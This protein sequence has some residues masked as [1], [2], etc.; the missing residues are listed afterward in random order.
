MA[1]RLSEAIQDL[2]FKIRPEGY[3]QQASNPLKMEHRNT[4]ISLCGLG[5]FCIC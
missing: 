2:I 1:Q 4:F 5:I 3:A